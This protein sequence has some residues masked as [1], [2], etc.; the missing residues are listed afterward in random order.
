MMFKKDY[1]LK[2]YFAELKNHNNIFMLDDKKM[3]R[4]N[5]LKC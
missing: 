3:E 5:D 2:L 4:R 1:E